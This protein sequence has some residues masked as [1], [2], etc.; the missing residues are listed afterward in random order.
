VHELCSLVF[1]LLSFP[2]VL[3]ALLQHRTAVGCVTWMAPELFRGEDYDEK[4][5][6]YSFSLCIY[7]V[8]TGQLPH[9]RTEPLKFANGTQSQS[10][11]PRI[12]LSSRLASFGLN[13]LHAYIHTSALTHSHSL[14]RT[15]SVFLFL[16][17]SGSLSGIPSP[18][19]RHCPRRSTN[20]CVNMY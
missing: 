20:N 9:G 19:S 17:C 18:C 7:E 5:D 1:R 2:A 6:V 3:C 12:R 10:A 13:H 15:H 8:F 11:P 4:V 16:S 14:L